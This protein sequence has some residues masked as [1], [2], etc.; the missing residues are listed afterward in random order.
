[1]DDFAKLDIRIGTIVSAEKM[2]GADKLLILK[3]DLGEEEPRQ[4]LAGIAEFIDPET[5]VGKQLPVIANLEPRT[6][7][8]YE[9]QGMILAIGTGDGFALLHPSEKVKAGNS[10]K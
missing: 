10:V 1:Y 8:G 9:S 6:L 4:I 5:L 7:R 3:I 2:E